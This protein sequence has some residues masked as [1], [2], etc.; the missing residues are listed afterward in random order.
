[1]YIEI[2]SEIYLKFEDFSIARFLFFLKFSKNYLDK[3]SCKTIMYSVL[4]SS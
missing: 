3:T 2:I 4:V 1:M